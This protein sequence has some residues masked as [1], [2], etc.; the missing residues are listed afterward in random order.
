[1]TELEEAVKQILSPM[2]LIMTGGM[3]SSMLRG[4]EIA[5]VR[6]RLGRDPTAREL[7]YYDNELYWRNLARW[8]Q[9]RLTSYQRIRDLVWGSS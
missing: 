1:M 4:M 7:W 3:V 6:E 8:H 9:D 5:A 2:T